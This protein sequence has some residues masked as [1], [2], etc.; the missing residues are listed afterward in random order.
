MNLRTCARRSVFDHW[1]PDGQQIDWNTLKEN[2]GHR[3]TRYARHS[4]MGRSACWRK[5]DSSK[6]TPKP[7]P[8][9]STV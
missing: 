3:S 4:R 5:T 6:L 9:G 8:G 7:C 2:K 1:G